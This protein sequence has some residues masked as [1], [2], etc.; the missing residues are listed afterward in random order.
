MPADSYPP[1]QS[2]VGRS[3]QTDA[4]ALVAAA[5]V[6]RLVLAAVVPLFPDETYYWEW[7]R[8]IAAGYFDHPPAIAFLIRAGTTVF[9]ATSIGVRAGVVL[10]GTIASWAM[11]VLAGRLAAPEPTL[12]AEIDA[13]SGSPGNAASRAALL[14]SVIPVALVGF[15]LATPDA[16]L[17]ASIAL[18]LVALERA[19]AAPPRSRD[20]LGWWI[21]AGVALGLAFCSKYTAVLIPM[22]V[23]VAFLARPSLRARL[24]EPGPY[25]A[26]AFA[27]LVLAPNL[28]WNAHNGWISFAFQ[29]QHGLGVTRGSALTRELNL[30]GGQ[31]GLISPIVAVLAAFAVARCLRGSRDDRRFMLAT[32][33]TTVI[34]FFIFS[35]LRKPVEANWPAPA[36]LAALPLLAVWDVRGKARKWLIAG[37]ALAAVSTLVVAIHA[38]TGILRLPVRRDP[39]AKAHGWDDL[40]LAVTRAGAMPPTSSCSTTWLA[41]DR[42]QDASELAYHLPGHPRV[43]ALNLGG[44]RNQYDLW[45]SLHTIVKTDDCVLFVVDAGTVGDA[46]VQKISATSAV[47]LAA[48]ALRW[49]GRTVAQRAIWLLR[50]FPSAPA[51]AIVLSPAA[52]ASVDSATRA[53]AARSAAIDSM[54]RIFRR[55]PSPYLVPASESGPPVS[56]S[57]RRAVIALRVNELHQTLLS[58]GAMAV[59]RDA[60]YPECTFVRTRLIEGTEIGFV[61]TPEGCKFAGGAGDQ[62]FVLRR[63]LI[64]ARN[65]WYVY[66]APPLG[67]TATQIR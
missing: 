14:V 10:A 62:R 50:G 67:E 2:R 39:I 55:G 63:V 43:F 19:I 54:V 26:T 53:F 36:L 22:G 60:R 25:V 52:S 31:L 48:A 24:T 13:G 64:P 58:A 61:H 17:L 57:D 41:A 28:L 66:A 46:V 56:N 5:T 21:A 33:A 40:A 16:P 12:H 1:P 45:P 7:S 35:A 23:L 8:R 11:V 32:V 65:D 44:R 37:C 51:A 29:L 30:I 42:Y 49:D 4:L 27:L 38:A 47:Q 20:A 9:G 6:L 18:T 3:V 34:V 15:V 59:Y